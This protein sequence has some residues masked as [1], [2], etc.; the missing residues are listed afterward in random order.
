M[1]P[2]K[3][4]QVAIWYIHRPLSDDLVTPFRLMYI[5]YSYM[6]PLGWVP[7]KGSATDTVFGN[8]LR[9]MGHYHMMIETLCEF[10]YRNTPQP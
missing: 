9:I 5:P 4:L 1:G 10:I 3:R 7:L 6:E 8:F 2:A